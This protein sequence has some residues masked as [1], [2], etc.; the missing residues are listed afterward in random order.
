MVPGDWNTSD[1]PSNSEPESTPIPSHLQFVTPEEDQSKDTAKF[2]DGQASDMDS[3]VEE[4]SAVQSSNMPSH[5][6]ISGSKLLEKAPEL[7][8]IQRRFT[9]LGWAVL[10]A[11]FLC[12]LG[13]HLYLTAIDTRKHPEGQVAKGGFS[14]AAFH[15]ILA[16]AAPLFIMAVGLHLYRPE[17]PSTG[18]FWLKFVVGMVLVVLSIAVPALLMMPKG[19]VVV[20]TWARAPPKPYPGTEK[21]SSKDQLRWYFTVA[22]VACIMS[23][24]LK[25]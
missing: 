20:K 14:M 2:G 21:E 1:R 22:V 25:K 10:L 13:S 11:T 7:V 18:L 19:Q 12:Y 23:K 8:P 15:F 5:L 4:P 6:K 3:E 24:V 9:K 16:L 17:T